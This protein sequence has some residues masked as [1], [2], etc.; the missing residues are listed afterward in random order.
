MQVGEIASNLEN[1]VQTDEI[2]SFEKANFEGAMNDPTQTIGD[3]WR[4]FRYPSRVA[5]TNFF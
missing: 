4:I 2:A 5:V 1:Y 3:T